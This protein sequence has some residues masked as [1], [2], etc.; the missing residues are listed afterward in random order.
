L[1]TSGGV[2]GMRRLRGGSRTH[3]SGWRVRPQRPSSYG[4]DRPGLPSS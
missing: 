2:W 3:P 4:R 1:L